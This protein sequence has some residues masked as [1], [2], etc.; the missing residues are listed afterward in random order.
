VVVVDLVVGML[1]LSVDLIGMP[2]FENLNLVIG[3][4]TDSNKL[5][6]IISS[7]END[8]IRVF[9][10]KEAEVNRVLTL[11]KCADLVKRKYWK[12]NQKYDKL[13]QIK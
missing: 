3:I 1:I 12:E 10:E 4:I 7:N 6:Y 11:Y 8:I 13:K 5:C 9:K 2:R